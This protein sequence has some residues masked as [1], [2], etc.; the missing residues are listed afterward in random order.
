MLNLG[1]T[2]IR[3]ERDFA[4]VMANVH[5]S[6]ANSPNRETAYYESKVYRTSHAALMRAI[7]I[8]YPDLSASDI[9]DAWVDNNVSI[10][11]NAGRIKN[12]LEDEAYAAYEASLW[13]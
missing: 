8:A 13:D 9:Y 11:Y 6:V 7:T 4:E 1:E 10:A 12:R 5:Y 2:V 3:D